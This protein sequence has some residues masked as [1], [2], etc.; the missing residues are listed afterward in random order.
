[1]RRGI[2]LIIPALLAGCDGRHN[3]LASAGAEAQRVEELFWVLL[4][5]A[6]VIWTIVIGAAGASN[7]RQV[8]P[9]LETQALS[10][11]LWG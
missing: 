2:L 5:G 3:W 7:R 6:A 10:F 9:S 8:D 4:L 11:I 1:M